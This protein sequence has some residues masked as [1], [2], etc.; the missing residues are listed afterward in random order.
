M[1]KGVWILIKW[2]N[3]HGSI[4]VRGTFCLLTYVTKIL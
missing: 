3:I 2:I 1:K 4:F